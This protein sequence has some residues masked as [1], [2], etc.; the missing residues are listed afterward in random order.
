MKFELWYPF[1][2]GAVASA[3]VCFFTIFIRYVPEPE[4]PA[5][6][7]ESPADGTP[8][9][10]VEAVRVIPLSFS[11]W[12]HPS[13]EDA[14]LAA[15]RD[16]EARN[17]VVEFFT[18]IIQSRELA[19][20][21]LSNA[22]AFDINPGLAFALC[23]KESR[24]NPRAVNRKNRNNSTDRGLFQL[25]SFSFPRLTEEAF[26]NP[27]IN[28]Y[29]GMAHLRWCLDTGG[30]VVAG[31]AMYN[32]GTTRVRA[33]TTPKKTL[34]YV[35]DILAIQLRIEELF[36]EYQEL[37]AAIPVKAPVLPAPEPEPDPWEAARPRLTLLSPA[38]GRP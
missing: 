21:I 30:S 17:G 32:A 4:R 33:G 37:A 25:N 15:Y 38:R 3:M 2:A 22:D 29:Y 20:V 12:E 24:F 10:P 35:S 7:A 14:I 26:F 34:D 19:A 13:G 27:N 11:G 28:A 5:R 31:L 36:S 18:G 9:A 16:D 23:W 1:F 6:F 8:G